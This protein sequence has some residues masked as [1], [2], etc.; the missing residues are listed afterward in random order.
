LQLC[1][2]EPGASTTGRTASEFLQLR[3][4][5]GNA[6]VS[7]ASPK[8]TLPAM[9][10]ESRKFARRIKSLR[11]GEQINAPVVSVACRAS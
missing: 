4:C 8:N 2:L 11:I 7:G 3:W 5:T 9:F 10:E 1:E 6:F